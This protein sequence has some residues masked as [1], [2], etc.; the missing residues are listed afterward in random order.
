MKV[1][2]F[3]ALFLLPCF[4]SS[5]PTLRLQ[6]RITWTPDFELEFYDQ[7]QQQQLFEDFLGE[8]NGVM[9]MAEVASRTPQTS[10]S[11]AYFFGRQQQPQAAQIQ[12]E[13][14]L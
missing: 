14:W 8:M 12:S 4:I 2:Q 1:L 9:A 5:S 13:F 6:K 7:Q 3:F 10:T 11:F